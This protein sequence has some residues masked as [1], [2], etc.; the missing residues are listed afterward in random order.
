MAIAA[1]MTK[2]ERVMAAVRGEAVDRIPVCFWHHFRP[3]G[4]GRRL[5]EATLDFFVNVFDL[6][7][8]KIMPDIPYP[9]PRRAISR[10]EDWLLIEPIARERSRFFRER[11]ATIRL[12]RDA[13]GFDAPIIM[14][15][16]SPLA[17]AMHFAASPELVLEH[18]ERY[19]A[20]VH[21]ALATIAENLREHIRD[22]IEQGADGVFFALQGCTRAVM[23]AERYRELGRP[24]DLLALQGAVDGWLNV[25]HVHGERDLL[26]DE[27][28]DYPV[29][30]LS[31]SDR[32]AGPSLAE[33]RRKT[34]KCLM[35]GWHEFGALTRGPVEEIRTEAEDAV[36]QTGGRKFILAN[37]CSVPDDTDERWLHAAR[38]IAEELR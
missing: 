37:G 19:P 5:A 22:C 35:G 36:R 38:Q 30:V 8:I 14:T 29:T 17:E 25:L 33:A 23:T 10:L 32:L 2:T 1:E 31:W 9:F 34:D 7:I 16:F 18:A 21:E 4:S 3:A 11:A 12:L 26:F 20:L 24:Y 6:D 15:V 27:V 13:V 28:L